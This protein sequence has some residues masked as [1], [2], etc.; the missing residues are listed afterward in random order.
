MKNRF[1]LTFVLILLFGLAACNLQKGVFATPGVSNPSAQSVPILQVNV[2]SSCLAGPG[3]G[4]AVVGI[5]NPG[6]QAEAV[7]R[8]PEGNYWLIQDPVSSATLCWLDDASV[9]IKGD[10]FTLPIASPVST[11]T[12]TLVDNPLPVGGCPTPIGGGPTPIYCGPSLG[13][14]CPTPIGGGPTPVSCNGSPSVGSGCPTPIGGGPTPVSCNGSP[15]VGS[16]CPTPIGGGPTPVSCNGSP[17]VGSGC[18]IPIT[19]GPT[20]LSCP[21]KI[22]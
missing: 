4:Y 3:P 11:P 20:P 12:P 1:V 19:G 10:P 15:S 8:T 13:S 6:Q 2:A 16:G 7:G 21:T 18:P 22:P 17:S 9:T 5:L 14:G